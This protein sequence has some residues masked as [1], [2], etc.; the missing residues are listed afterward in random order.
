MTN[1]KRQA[2]LI[3]KLSLM[4]KLI[5]VKRGDFYEVYG[6]DAP[7][8]ARILDTVCTS[9]QVEG[10]DRIPLA[11]VP[12]HAISGAIEELLAAGHQIVFAT[13]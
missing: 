10:G 13:L 5:F 7:I 2:Y 6:S 9:V 11:G 3:L 8:V 4:N 12:Y 1:E